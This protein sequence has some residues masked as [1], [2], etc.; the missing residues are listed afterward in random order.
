[1][2]NDFFGASVFD[3]IS[4]LHD[5]DGIRHV[6]GKGHIMCD[7]DDGRVRAGTDVHHFTDND[8]LI[9]DIQGRRRFIGKN[10][11][12]EESYLSENH[13][14]SRWRQY[15]PFLSQCSSSDV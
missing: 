9:R 3:G 14:A 6:R 2:I 13:D 5:K 11:L 10:Q 8:S 1:M 4:I 12:G 15:P 7:D